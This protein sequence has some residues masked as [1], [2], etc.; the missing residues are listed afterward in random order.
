MPL[1]AS[2]RAEHAMTRFPYFARYV[3]FK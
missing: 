1:T 2:C 3:F